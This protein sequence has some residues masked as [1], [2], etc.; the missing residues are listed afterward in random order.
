MITFKQYITEKAYKIGVMDDYSKPKFRE[1]RGLI[2][3]SMDE[4]IKF[5]KKTKYKSSRI[6]AGWG[7]KGKLYVWDANLA[8][9][10]DVIKGENLSHDNDITGMLSWVDQFGKFSTDDEKVWSLEL[11]NNAD[12]A[13]HIAKKKRGL[14]D[15]LKNFPD[16]KL[17]G[18]W[19]A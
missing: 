17:D 5:T 15:L 9:H 2:N 14:K 16:T 18:F 7:A 19:G 4:L 3:P 11:G 1:I 10:P 8:T 6:I 13:Q 12:E